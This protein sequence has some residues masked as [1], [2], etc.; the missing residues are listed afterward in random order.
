[1][2]DAKFS[3]L[4]AA[5]CGQADIQSFGR[6]QQIKYY[7]YGINYRLTFV[8]LSVSSCSVMKE[9]ITSNIPCKEF[10]Y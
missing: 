3:V 8:K 5:N 10:V 7:Y 4:V 6:I 1:M 2:V 9:N